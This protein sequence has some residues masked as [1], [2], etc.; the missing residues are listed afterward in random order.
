MKLADK[1]LRAVNGTGPWESSLR[2]TTAHWEPILWVEWEGDDKF[3]ND[4][5]LFIILAEAARRVN[6]S[7]VLIHPRDGLFESKTDQFFEW[8]AAN[9]LDVTIFPYTLNDFETLGTRIG[10]SRF[11]G[12]SMSLFSRES[13]PIAGQ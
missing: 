7:L 13:S 1:I 5:P 2:F 9:D 11:V 10:L 6:R 12:K 8:L 3:Y 4:G